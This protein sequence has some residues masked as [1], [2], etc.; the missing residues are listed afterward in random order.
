M[1]VSPSSQARR[2]DNLATE[3]AVR[4][5]SETAHDLRSPLTAVRES[6]RL[7]RDGDLGPINDD[8]QFCLES[9]VNQCGCIE[10][11]VGEM[12]QLERLRT[13]T[14]RVCRQTVSVT[15]VRAAVDN[16]L[17]PW[18]VPRDISILWDGADD[19]NMKVFADPA[20]LRRLVVNLATNAIRASG[21]GGFVLMRVARIRHGETIRW[22][23]V[24]R[25][26]G[27]SEKEMLRITDRDVSY[28]GGEGLGLAISRQL[29]ALHF[30]PLKIRSRLGRGTEVSFET[31][32]AG[33][34]S[35]ASVWT[36]WRVGFMTPARATRS[37]EDGS[38]EWTSQSG[39]RQM[40]LDSSAVSASLSHEAS[41]P[42]C[43]D[44][45]SAGSVA[46]G[47]TV[48][49]SAADQFDIDFQ[50][51]MQMFE[52]AYRVDT[53]RW[54]WC[55][56]AD[57]ESAKNRIESIA[58]GLSSRIPGIRMNWSDP[59]SIP[60]DEHRTVWQVSDLLVRQ[61]LCVSTIAPG[62]GSDEVRPGTGPIAPS[63]IAAARL[64]AELQRL[65]SDFRSQ[66]DKLQQQAKKLRPSL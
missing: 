39:D 60:L 15:D 41:R 46:L 52:L 5:I 14:P 20:M 50:S 6:I 13:G 35:V 45:L 55:L 25:G 57:L 21:E 23:V 3:A 31:P 51:Q 47:S 19:P 1:S 61:S 49:R 24:D 9:A 22:S 28:A 66:S 30:S 4:L 10:Q 34:R 40:R 27:I 56:D 32:V 44:A 33:P 12:V 8:Q 62:F 16:T 43:S 18:A 64:E 26:R 11:M 48:S 17:S 53:R 2:A 54:V 63:V 59:K 42:R 37:Q 36:A 29:A 58:E 7:V 65:T 38:L